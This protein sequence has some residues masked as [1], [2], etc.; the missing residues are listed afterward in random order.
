MIALI[1]ICFTN[2]ICNVSAG[3]IVARAAN[4]KPI[5]DKWFFY[6]NQWAVVTVV[7]F[8]FLLIEIS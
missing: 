5:N 1:C 3:V 8:I 4:K 2:I 6:V 7:S